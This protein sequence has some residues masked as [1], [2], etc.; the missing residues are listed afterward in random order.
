MK[1]SKIQRYNLNYCLNFFQ[2]IGQYQ[3]LVEIL[4]EILN[5]FQTPD[6]FKKSMLELI[7]LSILEGPSKQISH[8]ILANFCVPYQQDIF[9]EITRE[10]P[11]GFQQL[12]EGEGKAL[13]DQLITQKFPPA[14][15]EVVK[16]KLIEEKFQLEFEEAALSG[17]APSLL[18]LGFYYQHSKW[19]TTTLN[20]KQAKSAIC[21]PLSK[22]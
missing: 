21:K 5:E 22:V 20:R 17:Y 15:Y 14:I 2:S 1:L 18:R 9:D 4:K 12:T 13:K 8:Y 3:S 11:P 7:N 6:N 16:N 10:Y 19:V